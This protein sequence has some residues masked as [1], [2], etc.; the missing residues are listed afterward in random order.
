MKLKAFKTRVSTFYHSGYVTTTVGGTGCNCSV[1]RHTPKVP[2]IMLAQVLI[3][4]KLWQHGL[5]HRLYK[6]TWDVE[7]VLGQ[8]SYAEGCACVRF[9]TIGT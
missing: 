8:L 6:L 1:C 2:L 9:T 3:V 7:F 4:V 5:Q